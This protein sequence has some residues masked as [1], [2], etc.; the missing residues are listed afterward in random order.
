M[1]VITLVAKLV[2]SCGF[3]V[4]KPVTLKSTNNV[5]M[6]LSPSPVVAK[7]SE[8]H[9][10][11]G[12][13]LAV[14][15]ELVEL[16]APV[17]PPIDLGSEQPVNID[18]RTITFWRYAPQ[19]DVLEPNAGQIAESLFHLHSKLASIRDQAAFP[20]FREPL[21]TAVRSLEHPDLASDLAD[22][23]RTVLRET[24]VDGIAQLAK[25]TG[26]ERLILTAAM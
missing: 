13:E 24:L 25:T 1:D 3:D 9:V 10:R 6:W 2:R 11:A 20:S 12:R 23:D 21:M 17:V 19:D 8:E 15:T 18:T 26:S 7:I 14:V 22:V 16:A 4:H 5:V